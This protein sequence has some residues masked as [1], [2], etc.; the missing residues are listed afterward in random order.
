MHDTFFSQLYHQNI[1][2]FARMVPWDTSKWPDEW[3]TTY[4]KMYPRLPKVDLIDDEIKFDLFEAIKKRS[5]KREMSGEKIGKKDISILM[6]YSCGNTSKREDVPDTWRRAQPSGGGRYP[7]EMYGILIK[8][9]EDLKPGIFHYN[10]KNHQLEMLSSGELEKKELDKIASYEFIGNSALI[11]LMTAVFSRT[12]NKYGDRGY[13]FILQESGHIGQNISLI[14]E[15]LGIKCCS[16]GGFRVSD[17]QI[18][19]MLR[20]DGITESL[21][22]TI[23]LGK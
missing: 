9:G 21:V 7:I 3:K 16:L 5:S 11:L 6:K 4:Y 14:S 15:A 18:E 2:K 8:P 13:R 23:A 17:E 12:Q 20:I 1:K 10:V 22:Y 19:K